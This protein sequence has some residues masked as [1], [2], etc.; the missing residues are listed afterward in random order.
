M[1]VY[2][3]GAGTLCS[4]VRATVTACSCIRVWSG[5]GLG[6]SYSPR[7]S[8]STGTRSSRRWSWHQPWQSSRSIWSMFS[9]TWILGSP[10]RRQEFDWMII[11]SPFHLGH[12]MILA[13]QPDLLRLHEIMIPTATATSLKYLQKWGFNHFLGQPVPVLCH[14]LYEEILPDVQTKSPLA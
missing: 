13:C 2:S 3:R 6:R 14:S 4:L 11:A 7:V 9:E 12:S 10:M 5:S 8:S 1:E